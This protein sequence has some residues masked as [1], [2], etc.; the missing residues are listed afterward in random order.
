M[1]RNPYLVGENIDYIRGRVAKLS[2]FFNKHV[3][4]TNLQWLLER[5]LMNQQQLDTLRTFLRAAE[6]IYPGMVDIRFHLLPKF[7][8]HRNTYGSNHVKEFH[9]MQKIII[10][11]IDFFVRF[12]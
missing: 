10:N 4:K 7:I 12:P 3:D 6:E 8:T 9:I 2:K 11:K 1:R 5:G